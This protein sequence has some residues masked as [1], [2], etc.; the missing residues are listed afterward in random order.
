[1]T[2]SLENILVCLPMHV[3]ALTHI[4][5]TVT[6]REQGISEKNVLVHFHSVY[7][8]LKSINAILLICH[9]AM[10]INSSASS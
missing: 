8:Y 7:V 9:F 4:E 10:P 2:R 3:D 5:F 6:L 1:M